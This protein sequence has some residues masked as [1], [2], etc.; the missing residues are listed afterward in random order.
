MWQSVNERYDN[1]FYF[2]VISLTFRRNSEGIPMGS[3]ATARIASRHW[4]N[5]SLSPDSGSMLKRILESTPE[6]KNKELS[7]TSQ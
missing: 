1:V 2:Y 7:N 4:A 6:L 3:L 5:A